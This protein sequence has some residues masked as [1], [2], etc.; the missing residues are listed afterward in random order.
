MKCLGEW[1]QLVVRV[2]IFEDEK[3]TDLHPL[4]MTRAAFELR[5]GMSS[6][7]DKILRMVKGV[8]PSEVHLEVRGYLAPVVKMRLPE[9]KV[10][11]YKP[12]EDTIFINAR[13]LYAGEEVELSGE[14]VVAVK[15]GYVAY[16]YAKKSTLEKAGEGS[17]TEILSRLR[18][19]LGTKEA[20]TRL[21]NWPWDLVKYNAEMIR[22]EFE[23]RGK[24]GVVPDKV[25]VVGE[26]DLVYIDP[27][28][29]V[30][31]Y[32]VIDAEEGPVY[33]DAGAK[34]FP[35]TYIQ[36]PTYI[37]EK[38]YIMPCARIREGCSIGPVC[39]VGGEVEES[40]IHGYSN[41]YH[42]GFLGHAYVGQWVNLG[43]ITTNSDLKNDYSE[44]QVFINGKPV[45]TGEL[46]VGA[47]IGDHVKTSIGTYLNTGA[48]IG[49]MANVL[50]PDI[51]P[52]Y[53][54]PFTWYIKGVFSRG[55]GLRRALRTAET[56]MSRRGVKLTEE[57]RRM[58]EYL[59]EVTRKEREEYIRRSRRKKA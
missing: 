59:Y 19:E 24:G 3:V 11:E 40:I 30:Y 4:T 48:V 49:I 45:N 35:F 13:L 32:V 14:E 52:K 58:Y 31:P 22:R 51:S 9:Y 1:W 33:I 53:I 5:I 8:K 41:K 6:L 34:V 46:K 7:L 15:D 2:C 28:V 10:N 47:F 44:V 42:D 12:V 43:A 38:T 29:K 20:E 17:V 37:G 55:Y 50:A 54:P 57:E 16:A 27:S 56:M 25:E 23:W 26:K 21:I 39:R 36:G 18:G